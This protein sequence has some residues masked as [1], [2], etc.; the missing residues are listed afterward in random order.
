MN[1]T[2]NNAQ[3]ERKLKSRHIIMIALGG[4]IGTGI[5]MASGN[6]ISVAGPGGAVLAYCLMGV[7]VYFLMTSLGEMAALLPISGSFCDYCSRFV[8]PAFG[9]AMSYNYWFNWAIN[10]AVE[11]SAASILMQYWFPQVPHV[12]WVALFFCL[13]VFLNFCSVSLYGETEYWFSAIKV[14]TVIIFI[15]VGFLIILGLLGD[16]KPIDFTNWTIG[17][18][19]FHRG[20]IG[21]I[22]VILVVGFSFQGTEIF[23]VVAGEARDP[24]KSIPQ[25]MKTIFWR[26]L[27][28]YMLS[29]LVISFIM[30]YTD[31]ALISKDSDASSSPFTL[32]L[33]QAGFKAAATL[34]NFVILTAILS[35]AN[36]SI[37]T[38]TRI[39]WH[40]VTHNMAPAV[41]SKLNR[42]GVPYLALLVTSLFGAAAFL[43]SLVGS[44]RIFIYLVDI[45]SLTGFVAWIG[46]A[47]SH[48][49]FRK[50]Y[51]AQGKRL[52]ALPYQSRCFPFGPWLT[53]GMCSFIIVG[54]VFQLREGVSLG[55]IIAVLLVIPS[56][57]ALYLGYKWFHKTKL[58]PLADCDFSNNS[59]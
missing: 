25:S 22:D 20:W 24:K 35:A 14:S 50:A 31:P 59:D 51:I 15:I 55:E 30:P 12:H 48:Y 6:A 28:F 40:M 10:V 16:G 43:C 13:I 39:F 21:L 46:I 3:L 34:V 36:A 57:A 26:I 4:T 33:K 23:G 29:I 44:G 41:F 54:Q 7:M 18:A 42:K 58:V 49:R 19:P 37:Y 45:S 8:D 9:F 32:I 52:E 53:I 47:V 17:D 27:L 1:N 38:A 2:T 11:L 56:F 5:F